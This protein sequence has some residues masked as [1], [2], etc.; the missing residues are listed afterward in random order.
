MSK[1]VLDLGT[2]RKHAGQQAVIAASGDW[3]DMAL[4]ALREYLGGKKMPG[5]KMVNGKAHR[6]VGKPASDKFK[7]VD[8]RKVDADRPLTVDE[9]KELKARF[10]AVEKLT[11]R[12]VAT[13]VESREE[14]WAGVVQ[15]GST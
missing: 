12:H 10:I 1:S 8:D 3:S 14:Y 11:Q 7:L 9:R 15:S 2:A 6:K 4:S 13:H 5:V